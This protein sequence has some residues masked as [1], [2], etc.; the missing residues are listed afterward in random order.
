MTAPDGVHPLVAS[1]YTDAYE[2]VRPAYPPDAV[3]ALFEHT[4]IGPGADVV[5]LGPGT[6]KL[7]RRLV[8]AGAQLFDRARALVAELGG[9]FPLPHVVDVYWCARR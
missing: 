3:A 9:C 7:T 5:E 2:Q 4:G 1:G 8:D 6:G